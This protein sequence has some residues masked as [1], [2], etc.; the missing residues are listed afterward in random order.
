MIVRIV[1]TDNTISVECFLMQS[2]EVFRLVQKSLVLFVRFPRYSIYNTWEKTDLYK[3]ILCKKRCHQ[4]YDLPD[5]PIGITFINIS[6]FLHI[7]VFLAIFLQ[8]YF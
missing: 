7:L 5:Y 1:N 2:S 8:K 4:L 3:K 6:R